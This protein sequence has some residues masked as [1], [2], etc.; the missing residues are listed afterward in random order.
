[1][2]YSLSIRQCV[3]IYTLTLGIR[4]R[5]GA[6]CAHAEPAELA[7]QGHIIIFALK[8]QL[9]QG[10]EYCVPLADQRALVG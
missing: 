10:H 9:S 2:P 5:R 1:M 6:S 4:M 7:S 8:Y 3:F